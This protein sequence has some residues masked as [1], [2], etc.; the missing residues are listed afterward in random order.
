VIPLTEVEKAYLAGIVDGEGT[1]TLMKHHPNETPI[2]YV[3]VANNNL[4]LIKWI[5]SLVGGTICHR[6]KR[7]PHHNESYVWNA[8][9]D[10][11][12]RVLN[13]IKPYLFIKKEQAE[14]ITAKYKLVTSRSGK[15]TPEMLARKYELVSKVR[16]LNQRQIMPPIIR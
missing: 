1:V 13:E 3:S 12:L 2:P 16:E 10:R 11:A 7:M 6:T 15:Y 4:G 9:H 5:K 14:L 8:R